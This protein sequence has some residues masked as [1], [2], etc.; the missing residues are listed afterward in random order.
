MKLKQAH[1][2]S[3]LIVCVFILAAYLAGIIAGNNGWMDLQSKKER[4]ETIKAENR[5]LEKENIRLYRRID[6][7]KKD[8]EYLEH[9]VRSELRLVGEKQIVFKFEQP[10]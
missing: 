4:L 9:V 5:E 10:D 6:R 7:L 2:K 8:P 3:G 1:L